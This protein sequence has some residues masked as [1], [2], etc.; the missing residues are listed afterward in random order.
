MGMLLPGVLQV[1]V[2][3]LL[4]VVLVQ[5]LLVNLQAELLGMGI[6]GM[7]MGIKVMQEVMGLM[8]M[9][10]DMVLLVGVVGVS[11]IVVLVLV[12]E[13]FKGMLVVVTWEVATV[14]LTEIQGMEMQHGDLTHHRLLEIMVHRQM[15][16]IVDRLVMVGPMAVVR[17]DNLSSSKILVGFYVCFQILL[18]FDG[19]FS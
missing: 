1:P 19:G 3:V 9:Q 15:V 6:K 17:S 12:V 7:G 11:Q 8:V 18:F 4:V 16:L 2:V 10:V 13:S 14:M 5:H